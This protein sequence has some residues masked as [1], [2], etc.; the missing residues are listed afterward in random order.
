MLER[1]VLDGKIVGKRRSQV[2]LV[3]FQGSINGCVIAVLKE[4]LETVCGIGKIREAKGYSH[5]DVGSSSGE[6]SDL[7][8]DDLMRPAGR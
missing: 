1:H 6:M 8:E 7:I 3:S 5:V 4:F 2:I